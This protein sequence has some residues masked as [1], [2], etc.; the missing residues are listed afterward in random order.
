VKTGMDWFD[1]AQE[2]KFSRPECCRNTCG[3][4]TGFVVCVNDVPYVDTFREDPS[5]TWQAFLPILEADPSLGNEDVRLVKLV[6]D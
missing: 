2:V 6:E 4:I 5:M 3:A 1:I